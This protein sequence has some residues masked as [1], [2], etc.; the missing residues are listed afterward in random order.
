MLLSVHGDSMMAPIKHNNSSG[1]FSALLICTRTSVSTRTNSPILAAF[2]FST[3]FSY[4]SKVNL[5]IPTPVTAS[6]LSAECCLTTDLT[7]FLASHIACF[8][9]LV[10]ASVADAAEPAGARVF[11]AGL[12]HSCLRPLSLPPSSR[13]AQ[14]CPPSFRPF[15]DAEAEPPLG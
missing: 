6:Y 1:L 8:V 13:A 15:G 10:G 5:C 9:L 4:L 14:R 11:A 2:S 12:V 7:L 3:C